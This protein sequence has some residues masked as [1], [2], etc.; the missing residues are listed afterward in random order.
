MITSGILNDIKHDRLA[1]L[2]ASNT[3]DNTAYPVYLHDAEV[4]WALL[5]Q[6]T[7]M[8]EILLDLPG[9]F[10]NCVRALPRVVIEY[11][12]SIPEKWDLGGGRG[13]GR[14]SITRPCRSAA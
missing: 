14:L 1:A 10:N 2:E 5:V 7:H 9:Y 11:R 13:N 4:G 6:Q 8:I 12:K 3:L